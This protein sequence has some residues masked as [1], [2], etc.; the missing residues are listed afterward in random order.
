MQPEKTIADL[1]W[2]GGEEDSVIDDSGNVTKKAKV[3]YLPE[4]DRTLPAT[5]RRLAKANRLAA[6]SAD[7]DAVRA[8]AEVVA[9]LE[10]LYVAALRED[11][12][13]DADFYRK[14]LRSMYPD[15]GLNLSSTNAPSV[16]Q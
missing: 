8:R 11:R 1:S 5:T 9:T 13:V 7:A 10:P 14:A 6:E 2:A 12:I 4:N 16:A 3:V 15:W